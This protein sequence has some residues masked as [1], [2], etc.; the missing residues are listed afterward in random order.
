MTFL[1]KARTA[2]PLTVLYEFSRELDNLVVAGSK[3]GVYAPCKVGSIEN[4]VGKFN[5]KAVVTHRTDVCGIL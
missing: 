4:V 2:Y 1:I 3:V 5:F